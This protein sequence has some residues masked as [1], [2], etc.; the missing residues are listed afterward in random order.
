M[1]IAKENASSPDVSKP[2]IQEI[3]DRVNNL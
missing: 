3:I 2:S 1:E